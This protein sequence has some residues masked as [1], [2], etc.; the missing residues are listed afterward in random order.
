MIL[1]RNYAS[2]ILIGAL[3]WASAVVGAGAGEYVYGSQIVDAGNR[4][5]AYGP[6]F[7]DV[8]HGTCGQVGGH[9]RVDMGTS[10]AG[11]NVWTATSGTSNAAMRSYGVGML[12]GAGDS[13]HLRVR[14][15]LESY[16]PFR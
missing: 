2:S 11:L 7:A 14:S 1:F 4:C 13:H 10:H 16:N 15:G 8:G 5:A 6:G 3:V 12:P 9:V